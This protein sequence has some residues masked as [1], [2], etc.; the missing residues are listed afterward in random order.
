MH[1]AVARLCSRALRLKPAA[2]AAARTPD[3]KPMGQ[4]LGRLAPR[5]GTQ[6]RAAAGRAGP[7]RPAAEDPDLWMLVGL[8]NPGPRYEDTR[9]NVGFMLVDAL[10]RAEGLAVDRLQETAQVH[11]A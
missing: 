1:L 5:S 6:Q 9:H 2:L 10:A 7:D 4:A 8:G 11:G 3:P